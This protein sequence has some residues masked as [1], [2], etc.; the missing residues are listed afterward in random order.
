MAWGPAS[1]YD[2]LAE[3]GRSMAGRPTWRMIPRVAALV[4]A[5]AGLAGCAGAPPGGM[6]GS[7]PMR[8]MGGG[9]IPPATLLLMHAT[10]V[11]LNPAGGTLTVKDNDAHG[12]WTVA[13]TKE[14]SILSA[15]GRTLTLSDFEVGQRVRI[16]GFSRIEEI[17]TAL[18]LERETEGP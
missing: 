11:D 4:I 2:L 17:L 9:D 1:G 13:V 8:G 3:G 16:R 15:E 6:R 5:T 18:E 12:T 10:I 14:T 7:G